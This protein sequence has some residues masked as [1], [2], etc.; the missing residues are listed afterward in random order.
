MACEE[1]EPVCT[2]VEAEGVPTACLWPYVMS[3][4]LRF[5]DESVTFSVLG[6]EEKFVLLPW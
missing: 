6:T 2:L 1:E 4:S 3:S 5:R